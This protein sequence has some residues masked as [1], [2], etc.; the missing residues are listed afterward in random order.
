[1]K[2][3]NNVEELWTEDRRPRNRRPTWRAC[4]EEPAAAAKQTKDA[5]MA[6][7]SASELVD[8]TG[9]DVTNAVEDAKPAFQG[10][11]APWVRRA[12]RGEP[13]RRRRRDDDDD[14]HRRRR[15]R[16]RRADAPGSDT[17]GRVKTNSARGDERYRRVGREVV[18][19]RLGRAQRH[20]DGELERREPGDVPSADDANATREAR[21]ARLG[22]VLKASIVD[23]AT[24]ALSSAPRRLARLGSSWGANEW[25]GTDAAD[26][27][28][29]PIRGKGDVD[30]GVYVDDASVRLDSTAPP[31]GGDED[32]TTLR[33]TPTPREEDFQGRAKESRRGV[34]QGGT[35]I[36]RG[37]ATGGDEA[38]RKLEELSAKGMEDD[39][40][41][42]R[43]R[44]RCP[45]SKGWCASLKR[46]WSR[47]PR[48]APR[49]NARSRKRRHVRPRNRRIR[50]SAWWNK[51]SCRFPARR[52]QRRVDGENPGG[53][54]GGESRQGKVALAKAAAKVQASADK[55][56]KNLMADAEKVNVKNGM[57]IAS[58][59]R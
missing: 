32:A 58:P 50:R 52:S 6:D 54:R 16:A 17:R 28:W 15:L 49:P 23:A 25:T 11:D 21:E 8:E 12:W 27:T 18:S 9:Q 10:G 37:V 5:D 57:R 59:G 46:R 30:T 43:R 51:P 4:A 20:G 24:E 36:R 38:Q 29:D 41:L 47:R 42:K 45:N 53:T 40:D 34:R 1:M 19:T 13:W 48:R 33:A 35:Q 3:W 22:S 55:A 44:A 2:K 39:A 14:G 31:R 7:L 56:L 26:A